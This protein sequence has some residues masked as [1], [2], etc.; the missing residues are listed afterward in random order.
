M[1]TQRRIV[2]N[3]DFTSPGDLL[4]VANQD[5]FVTIKVL[6]ANP[7]NNPNH[8]AVVQNNGAQ[9]NGAQNNGAQNNGA[10]NNE[11]TSKFRITFENLESGAIQNVWIP[12][13]ST[14][15]GVLLSH[16]PIA[17]NDRILISSSSNITNK[18]IAFGFYE[19]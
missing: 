11:A 6:I 19:I 18:Y 5:Q 10:Q 3:R 16:F 13:D 9:N 8:N 17:K 4:H 2:I 1:F 15:D 12:L 7:T 14:K